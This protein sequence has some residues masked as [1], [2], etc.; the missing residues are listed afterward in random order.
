MQY[1]KCEPFADSIISRAPK[2][3]LFVF[4]LLYF[5][6]VDFIFPCLSQ[7][8]LPLG[9]FQLPSA[10]SLSPF[11][12]QYWSKHSS[13]Y[14]GCHLPDFAPDVSSFVWCG[15]CNSK[16]TKYRSVEF[17][18]VMET[19]VNLLNFCCSKLQKWNVFKWTDS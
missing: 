17:A 3:T 4:P 12:P 2:L 5:I 11:H 19:F 18:V 14:K 8:H 13:R 7:F 16:L 10:M 6:T 15:D 1:L 9:W